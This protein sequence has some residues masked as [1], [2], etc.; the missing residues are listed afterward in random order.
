MRVLTAEEVVRLEQADQPPRDRKLSWDSPDLI[1]TA[2]EKRGL[3]TRSF[4]LEEGE[5]ED[6]EWAIS[7][8][9]PRGRLA[10]RVHRA[11]LSSMG[12]TS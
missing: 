1:T 5:D 8:L 10:L 4:E 6:I 9:T 3:V 2:L 12:V 11:Y 7:W